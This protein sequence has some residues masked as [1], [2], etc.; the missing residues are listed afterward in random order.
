MHL[1]RP[2]KE[3]IYVEKSPDF[4]NDKYPNHIFKLNKVLYE[5]K[6]APRA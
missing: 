5:L 3:E 6:Q 2:I 4:E 1:S